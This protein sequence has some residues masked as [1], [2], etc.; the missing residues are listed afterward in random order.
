MPISTPKKP[1]K[2]LRVKVSPRLERLQFD[3][4]RT[5][6]GPFTIRL[7]AFLYNLDT[8]LFK[9]QRT[10]FEINAYRVV[11]GNLTPPAARKLVAGGFLQ[12]TNRHLLKWASIFRRRGIM[13]VNY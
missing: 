9:L 8:L 6:A 10:I 4:E 12:L 3:L 11:S 13:V 7:W 5:T 1:G 2:P